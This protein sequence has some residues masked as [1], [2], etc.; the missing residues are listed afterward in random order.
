LAAS[1][2]LNIRAAH[3]TGNTKNEPGINNNAT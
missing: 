2:G 1:V 3:N